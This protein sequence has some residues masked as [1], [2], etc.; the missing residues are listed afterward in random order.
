MKLRFVFTC[1]LFLGACS[2]APP[3]VEPPL[4]FS[5]SGNQAVYVANHG[6]HTGIVVPAAAL[7]E[8]LTG[9][10][11]RFG[12]APWLEFGWGDKDFY[13]ARTMTFGLALKA[14]L[15]PTNSVVRV[16]GITDDLPRYFAATGVAKLC[17][18][19]GELSSLMDFLSG[20]FARDEAG[21]LIAEAGTATRTSQF[22]DGVGRYHLLNTCNNWTAKGLVSL[23]MDVSAAFKWTSGGVM[24]Y[25]HK[26]RT[27]DVLSRVD[28]PSVIPAD[29]LSCGSG[30]P[31]F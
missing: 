22:Y 11:K 21:K 2:S 15:W 28:N 1:V 20:S 13:Q 4:P 19:P 8:S 27:A 29:D 6:W 30:T 23:G 7:P 9:V 17:V 24:Q 3:A 5:G 10:R 12:N 18:T 31:L 26:Q 25:L 16:V 14:A